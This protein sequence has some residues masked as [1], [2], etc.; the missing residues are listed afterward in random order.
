MND[1]LTYLVKARPK[2]VGHHF[3]FLKD[4]LTARTA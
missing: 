4:V 2:A 3:A 1:A